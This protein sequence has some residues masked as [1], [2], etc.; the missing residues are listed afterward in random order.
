MEFEQ[1][2][3]V[4]NLRSECSVTLMKVFIDEGPYG[5]DISIIVRIRLFRNSARR[6]KSSFYTAITL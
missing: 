2:K 5:V 6:V 1:D 4:V 3:S